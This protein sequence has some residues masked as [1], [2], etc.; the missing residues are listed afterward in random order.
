[1]KSSEFPMFVAVAMGYTPNG[2]NYD[3]KDVEP[4]HA[5]VALGAATFHSEIRIRF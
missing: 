2:V 3:E 5:E 1:M 4:V